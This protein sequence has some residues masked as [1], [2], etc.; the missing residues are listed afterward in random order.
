MARDFDDVVE[1][2]TTL[3]DEQQRAAAGLLA[4]FLE[5]YGSDVHLTP[6][7][8]AEV[9]RRLAEPD[10]FVSDKDVETF[11]RGIEE[12]AHLLRSPENSGRLLGALD[13]DR[14]TDQ[15]FESIDDL[16]VVLGLPVRRKLRGE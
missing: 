14:T 3:P 11:F 8:I 15:K 1:E 12:T 16:R 2:V 13:G 6:E 5:Q 7:Q 4:L 10:D 9:E